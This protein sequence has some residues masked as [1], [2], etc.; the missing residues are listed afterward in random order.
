MSVLSRR[1]FMGG[2]AIVTA[3]SAG[4]SAPR[5][6]S[7]PTGG[8]GGG[9][10]PAV[11]GGNPT[12]TE[13]F[14]S[15][16]MIES[17]DEERF[18]DSLHQKQWC[19]LSG[20]ITTEF[21]EEWARLLGVRHAVGVVNGT[22]AIHSALAAL[23]VGPGDEVIVPPYTF[24]ATVNAVLQCY[25]LP[26][27]SDS[28]RETLQMEV[29]GLESKVT[30]RTRCIIPVHLGGNVVNM[31]RL[32]SL[33]ESRG[34]AVVEDAC[35]AH[36][37]E[38]R[39]KRV[40]GL[41]NAGC[42]SFQASK[43]LPSGEGGAVVTND[44]ELFDRVHAYQNNG[45]D[46]HTG[47]RHGYLHQGSNFRMTEFQS[48]LLLA[49]LTRFEEQCRL[50]EKNAQRLSAMLEEIPGITPA[51]HYEGCTRNTYYI[52]MARYDASGF[53]GLSRAAFA[54]ALRREGI[55]VGTGYQPLNK[56]PFLEKTLQSRGFRKIYTD[57]EL[58]EYRER[59]HCPENDRLCGEGLFFSQQILLG[60][61]D[62]ITQVAEA[63]QKISRHA[64]EIKAQT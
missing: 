60:N 28:D 5:Q 13:P 51:K 8:T 11:L 46:R 18:L 53:D 20:T 9:G 45:R 58:A 34:L 14:P 21:E 19:R 12:R 44:T 35:Q 54:N 4:L 56:E 23:D 31:D 15:W 38:W 16:P 29:D 43:I 64:G 7:A 10:R 22:N 49:Q 17:I 57:K 32:L 47:T 24:V 62:D 63:I 6:S 48:A 26:V 50:R 61:D 41:G 27:F 25:A 1:A 40:G 52:Y 55:S 30:E 33:A 39:G 36:Y 42:F 37:A 3:G 2:A 59:N